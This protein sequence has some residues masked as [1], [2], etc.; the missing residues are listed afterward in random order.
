MEK[1]QGWYKKECASKSDY[2]KKFL[3]TKIKPQDDEVTDFY[4]NK[5]SKVDPKYTCLAVISL[6]AA[7][8]KS[9]KMK[10]AICTCFKRVS[11]Y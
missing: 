9:R 6:D 8:K 1:N 3:E 7:L 5:I 4:I 11:I 2:N 10:I